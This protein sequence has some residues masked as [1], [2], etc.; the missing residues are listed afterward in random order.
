MS[1]LQIRVKSLEKERS[2]LRRDVE[3][4]DYPEFAEGDPEKE[5]YDQIKVRSRVAKR[6]LSIP[7]LLLLLLSNC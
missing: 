5:I 4:I 3:S 6:A 2:R 1:R 7:A